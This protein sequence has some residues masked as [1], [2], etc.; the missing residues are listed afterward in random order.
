[1][2]SVNVVTTPTILSGF[3]YNSAPKK[4]EKMNQDKLVI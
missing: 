1:M 4:G 3:R 2:R